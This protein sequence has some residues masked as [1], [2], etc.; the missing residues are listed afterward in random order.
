MFARD[1]REQGSPSYA[2]LCERLAGDPERASIVLDAPPAFHTPLILLA[3]VHYLLL[4][5]ADGALAAYYATVS[6]DATRPVDDQLYSTFAAFIDD[7]RAEVKELVAS[8][9][10]Q[11]NEARRTVVTLPALGMVAAASGRPLA[12]LEVGASA[13]LTLLVDRY[14]FRIGS[15]QAGVSESPVQLECAVEGELQPPVPD[16]LEVAW[17]LGLDLHPLD[18]GE[19]ETGDWLRALVWPEHRDR[20]AVLEA[21]L[22]VAR[23]DPPTVLAGDLTTDLPTLAKRA[24]ADAALAITSTWTLAYVT[25]ELRRAFAD[26][27]RRV[28]ADHGR[29]VWLVAGE[30][31]AVLHS[32]GLGLVDAPRDGSGGPSMLALCR[33]RPDGTDE[34]RLLA[35]CHAHGRWIRWLDPA[36]AVAAGEPA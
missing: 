28:A 9:T 21:A 15:V 24:P 36:S 6:G 35:E 27:L 12:L 5:G 8:H 26:D 1:V 2:V 34:S 4:S 19:P 3:A 13:G 30:G 25:P 22:A 10:T 16:R 14:G 31:Q 23:Q 20:M 11:T 17:R 33:F 18:V 32:L 29:E 7:H